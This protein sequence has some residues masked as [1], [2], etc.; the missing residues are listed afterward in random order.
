[1]IYFFSEAARA[2]HLEHVAFYEARRA[3]LG[4]RYL[5]AFDAAIERVCE[6]PDRFAVAHLPDI[7]RLRLPGLPV[8]IL[9]RIA[10]V[11]IDVLA[12]AHH[13]RRPG[14]WRSRS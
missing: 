12:L 11:G 14:Y 5:S 7:R 1:V 9:Y 8:T 6:H 10:A 13:S 4:A 3:G 2:E